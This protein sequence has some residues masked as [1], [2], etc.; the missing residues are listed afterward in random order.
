MRASPGPASRSG[1][2]RWAPWLLL[3]AVAVGVLVVG[4]RA[5]SH[6]TVDQQTL[7]IADQVRCPVCEGQSAAQSS[8]PASLQIR[9][10]IHRELVAGESRQQILDGIVAAY[11][12]SI[13]E[14]PQAHGVGL[15]VWVVPVVAVAAALGLLAL[16]FSRWRPTR[17]TASG[18]DRALVEDALRGAGD[19]GPP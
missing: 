12:P 8:A 4:A 10:Q 19:P 5:H 18:D 15:L 13:L 2:R 17:R 7:Q 16:A 11:G 1:L 3:V 14:R 6:P 9:A